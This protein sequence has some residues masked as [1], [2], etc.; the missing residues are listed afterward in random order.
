MNKNDFIKIIKE[1][2]SNFDFLGNDEFLKEQE[3]TDLLT[4]PDLQKQFICDSLLN[5]N[6]KIK[7][8]KVVDSY[9]T[10]NWDEPNMEDANSL[11]LEYSLDLEYLYDSLKEPLKFNL[12]FHADRIDITVDG[13]Y[14]SGNWSGTMPDSTEPSGEAWYT[15]FDWGDID[16]KLHI[17]EGDEV[18][19]TTFESAPPKIQILFIREYT[20]NFIENETLQLKT[21]EKYKIQDVPYC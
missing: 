8:V 4:N 20:R 9:I 5:Y 2:V 18:R 10:G 6:E 15:G 14:D 13:W 19:F 16:V 1:E 7:V 21:G 17:M 11:T 12:T 3:V